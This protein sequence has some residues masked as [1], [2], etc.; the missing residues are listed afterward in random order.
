MK[1]VR[2]LESAAI[3]AKL[4]R[5]AYEVAERN[6]GKQEI[7]ISGIGVRGGFVAARL[8][9]KLKTVADFKVH[10]MPIEI[11]AKSGEI[12]FLHKSPA[13]LI[14]G[15]TIVLVDDVLYSGR[16][17]FKALEAIM[18]YA[19]E[20]VQTALLI[21]RGHRSLPLSPDFVGMVLATTLKQHVQVEVSKDG[22]TAEV[23]LK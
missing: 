2:I 15:A 18:G 20:N 16:T 1:K 19:P 11:A 4:N 3:T 7:V 17:L 13:K 21:D 14:N 6:Y 8:I 12:S 22:K 5:M 23:F 10:S 9:A